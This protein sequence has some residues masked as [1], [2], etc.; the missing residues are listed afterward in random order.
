MVHPA[1]EG[2]VSADEWN[3]AVA[4]AQDILALAER[5]LLTDE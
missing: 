2:K 3:A 4:R 5:G 1:D